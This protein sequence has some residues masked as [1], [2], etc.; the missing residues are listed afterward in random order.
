LDLRLKAHNLGV[1]LLY[2]GFYRLHALAYFFQRFV[3][4]PSFKECL[5]RGPPQ[6]GEHLVLFLF[7]L[8]CLRF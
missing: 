1:E 6:L 8:P 3:A 2:L 7:Q 5:V 4:Q